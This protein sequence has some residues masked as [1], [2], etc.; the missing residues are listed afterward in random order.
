M[1][2]EF[3]DP[4]YIKS[5]LDLLDLSISSL[6]DALRGTDSR[7]LTDL[8]NIINSVYSRL[9]VALSTRASESTLSALSGK[10]PSAVAL[11]D[12]LSNPATTIIGSAMLGWDGT[13]WRRV[14]VDTSSRLKIVAES[15]A[16]PPN[17]DV[18]LSSIK[19]LLPSS[20]TSS[21]NFKVAL[22]EDNVGLLK[23]AKIPNPLGVLT[24][25]DVIGTTTNALAVVPQYTPSRQPYTIQNISVSTTEGSTAIA[26]PGAKIL[27]IKNRGDTDVLI[28]I[29]GS[30]PATNPLVVRAK[31]IKVIM[32]KGVTQVNY[33]V[34]SGTSTIDIE[35]YN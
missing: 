7:T 22:Q 31:T 26:S 24:S 20:L 9:D 34:S 21:G 16:N 11:A 23:D 17:L 29:N 33:K 10:F 28:G 8:Y 30:V 35:Y 6:R 18:A 2:L 14:A 19:A 1:V 12:N 15:I 27:V 5:K 4:A 25:L 13:Y 32:H 3:L